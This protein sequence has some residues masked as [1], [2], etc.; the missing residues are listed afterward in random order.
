MGLTTGSGTDKSAGAT[1]RLF[2][3]GRSDWVIN[4]FR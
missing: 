1:A 2:L 4:F 3:G